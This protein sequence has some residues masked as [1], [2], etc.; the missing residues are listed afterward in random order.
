MAVVD[1][2]EVEITNI[3]E[4]EIVAVEFMTPAG[5]VAYRDF[6][7]G[8]KLY[9]ERDDFAIVPPPKYKRLTPGGLV[10]L[11][12][13]YIVR[14]DDYVTDENGNVV[15]VLCSR[16]E[17]SR[18]GQD[19]SG[20]KAKGVIHWV[21]ANDCID[22]TVNKL[23][24]LLLPDD[25]TKADFSDRLNPDSKR[26]FACAKGEPMLASAKG[27][28]VFQFMRL[29]YFSLDPKSPEGTLVFNEV[30]SL[31]DGYKPAK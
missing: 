14:C 5:D 25:G 23:D 2:I 20:V 4:D 27:G 17:N 21:N 31:K 1:P 3:D 16:I 26:T 13:A 10:R 8:K 28:D 19:T 22:I 12:G 6:K 30:V 18:S 9:I 7:F 15:K 29:S 24:Y 11:K